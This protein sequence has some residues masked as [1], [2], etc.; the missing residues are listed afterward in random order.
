M[1]DDKKDGMPQDTEEKAVAGPERD[2]PG[3]AG[4][5]G[6]SSCQYPK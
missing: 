4:G 1:N 6:S 3:S 5:G 2:A